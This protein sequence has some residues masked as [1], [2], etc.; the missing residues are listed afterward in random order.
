MS[1]AKFN[2]QVLSSLNCPNSKHTRFN[3]R[4]LFTSESSNPRVPMSFAVYLDLRNLSIRLS[5]SSSDKHT[6]V[7]TV[8]CYHHVSI[9]IVEQRGTV[10]ASSESSNPSTDQGHIVKLPDVR[11]ILSSIHALDKS[12]NFV[13]TTFLT[14][15]GRRMYMSL[16]AVP[17]KCALLMSWCLNFNSSPL[18]VQFADNMIET[19]A[20]TASSGD[21]AQTNSQTSKEL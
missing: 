11:S 19:N 16:W 15:A 1:H 12:A 8:C 21:L 5:P 3:S 18:L 10:F 6:T 4:R 17:W 20:F 13:F 2:V 9:W 7:I 14:L